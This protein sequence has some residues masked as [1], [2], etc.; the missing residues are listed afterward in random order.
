[1]IETAILTALK[2]KR[3]R[4]AHD[5][6]EAELRMVALRTDLANVDGC[7]RIFGSDIDPET[8]RPKATQGESPAG[9]PKGAGTRTALEILR[10]TGQAMSTP[11]L[12]ACVLQRWGRPLEA[13]AL[14]MLVKCIQGNFSRRT[15]GI[16]EFTRDTYPGR[17]R[18]TSLP[19]P[20]NSAE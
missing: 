3:A 7:L 15:D 18:L 11:E 10:E 14:S 17:W 20:A 9:L 8:I 12:A 4:L 5:L 13:R 19:A 16:V 6:K 1:M 2:D